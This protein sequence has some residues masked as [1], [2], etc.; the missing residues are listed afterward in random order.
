V[1]KVSI[2]IPIYNV[3]DYLEKCLESVIGQ[4]FTD[5]EILCV[6]DGPTD[7]S[8]MITKKYAEKD[9]RIRVIEQPNSGVSVAR[10]VA[11]SKATGEYIS[12]VDSDDWV[13]PKFIE[14]LYNSAIATDAEIVISGFRTIK[15]N[16]VVRNRSYP[17]GIFDSYDICRNLIG[18]KIDNYPWNKLFR[19]EIFTTNDIAFPED[20]KFAE[21]FAIMCQLAY[22]SKKVMI[23]DNYLYFYRIRDNSAE[24]TF[25]LQRVTGFFKA[26]KVIKDF[27]KRE[28]VYESYQ[29]TYEYSCASKLL[30]TAY[31]IC[32]NGHQV[33]YYLDEMKNSFNLIMEREKRF[34]PETKKLLSFHKRIALKLLLYNSKLYAKLLLLKWI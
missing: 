28:N 9:S 5:I 26:F 25:N 34:L 23:V 12:F 16:K 8:R 18:Y 4:T 6:L 13:S 15:M 29:V 27:L 24:K 2:I 10:N 17:S 1:A 31:K 11:L 7:R 19:K 30:E 3:E 14:T 22:Y 21:D 33:E 32:R 20:V